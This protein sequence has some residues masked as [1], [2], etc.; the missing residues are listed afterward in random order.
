M[1][2]KKVLLWVLLCCICISCTIGYFGLRASAASAEIIDCDI[3]S[4]YGRGEEFV[5]PEGKVSYK[6][7][8]KSPESKY[9]VFPSGKANAGETVVLSEE[10]KYELVFQAD[11][12]GTVVVAKKT[13]IVRKS[14]IQVND[15]NSSAE[16]QDGKIV[17]SLAP[18]D[19]FSYNEILDLTTAT[20][21]IPLLNLEFDPNV[22]GVADATKIH[23]RFTDLYDESNYVIL[24][25]GN[26]PQAWANNHSY[27]TAGAAGQPQ[28]GIENSDNPDKMHIHIDSFYNYGTP[29]HFSMVGL[30]LE[31]SHKVL[32]VYFDYAEK[33]FYADRE[34]F[35][36]GAKRIVVDLDEPLYFGENLWA[37]F[38]SGK[39]KMTV[40]ASNYQSSTCNFSI[41]TIN[42]NSEFSDP[43]DVSAPI[44]SVD[45]GYEP[46]QLPTAL[47][48]KP[49]PLFDALAVD[50]HD[51]KIEPTA[52]VYYRYYSEKPVNVSVEDGKFTPT[53][54]GVYVIEYTATD[55]SGNV[56]KACV[57]VQAVQ[58]DGLQVELLDPAAETD[59]GV[60]VKLISGISYTDASGKVSYSVK[61]KNPTTGE[62]TEVNTDTFALIPMA[63]GDWEIT[64]TVKDY[65]S[66]VVKT[67]TLSSNH[68][69]QP[70]VFDN[71]AVPKYFI[72]GATYQMPVLKGYDFS[73]G[74]GVLTDMDIFV[75]ENGSPERK[76]ENGQYIPENV[77][78][79]TVIYRLSVD[80]KVCEKAYAVTVVDVGY[81][82]DLDLSKYFV[83]STGTATA[84]NNTA[85]ITYEVEGDTTLDFVNFVQVKNL[86][87]SFQI[88]EKN[89]YNKVHI[90]LTDTVTGKQVKLSY[91]RT[92][93]GATFCVNDGTEKKLSSSFDGMNKSFSLEFSNDTSI[94]MPEADATMEVRTFLDGSEFTGFTNNVAHFSVALEEVSGPS[95]IVM[96]NL[97]TQTLNN[98]KTDRFAPQIIVETKSGDRGKGDKITLTGA[99]AYDT[100]DPTSTLT[101]EVTDPDGAY[102][103]DENG[104]LLDGTQ[105]PTVDYTFAMD[106]YG[107][108]VIRYVLSD[109]KE[110]TEYYVYAVTVKDVEG[111]TISFAKHEETAKVGDTVEIAGTEVT[112]NFT[113]ACTV[114]AYVFNPECANVPVTDGKFEAAMAGVYTVRY[115]AFDENGNYAFAS[116]E[117]VVR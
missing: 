43:G 26:V 91:N 35:S 77:G 76:I 50:G 54:E 60:S 82:G 58:G 13:F 22:I 106:E 11:F 88:G 4:E 14:I 52:A 37:G 62:E 6:G 94:V 73:S 39:V 104:V 16:I 40:T 27:L 115:M 80:G 15:D 107:D 110:N 46:D 109:G 36:G 19:V 86:S 105:D 72:L 3:P 5:M 61:A 116:Y 92:A 90:Y 101:L 55:L 45:T 70:Q 84:Q 18:K 33:A 79:A 57:S 87:Y 56:G 96:N 89:A 66:T 23:F 100:L 9:V 75:M 48:G 42:G 97:N 67:F 112:D 24:T 117:I 63:D 29:I 1:S 68:T 65:V 78:K 74:K 103:A 8:E 49:Y 83:A 25:L 111:P 71:A 38:T 34:I 81:T 44:I 51:G 69:A 59:T 12:D 102:V 7:Q 95:Q 17:V 99:F 108:Y 32:T 20:K 93:D 98:S 10:G 31:K 85:N 41:S 21:D 47:V 113:Q 2:K 114:V 30:P 53:K 64:V 28:V